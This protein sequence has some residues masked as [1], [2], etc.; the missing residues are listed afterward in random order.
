MCGGAFSNLLSDKD[1]QLFVVN[2]L[3]AY[4]QILNSPKAK[5][6]CSNYKKLLDDYQMVLQKELGECEKGPTT[7][8]DRRKVVCNYVLNDYSQ[9][10]IE[11]FYRH[12][13]KLGADGKSVMIAGKAME[14]I[15]GP[16]H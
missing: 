11:T 1:D 2:K 10:I 16:I 3:K 8:Y 5:L 15:E 12:W 6:A 13:S 14:Q 4:S 7:F 9:K